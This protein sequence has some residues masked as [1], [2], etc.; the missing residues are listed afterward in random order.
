[1]DS[2]MFRKVSYESII[3]SFYSVLLFHLSGS[4]VGFVL[5]IASSLVIEMY[6]FAS[7]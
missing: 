1:M 3:C 4:F 5:K 2:G 7:A 6:H